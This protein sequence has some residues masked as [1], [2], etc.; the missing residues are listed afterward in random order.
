MDSL[1]TYPITD[2]GEQKFVDVYV[3]ADYLNRTVNSARTSFKIPD[4][5]DDAI[6]NLDEQST[7]TIEGILRS[8]AREISS[9]YETYAKEKKT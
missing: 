7:I 6:P 5:I 2:N 9:M 3:V 4:K 1:F 8:I